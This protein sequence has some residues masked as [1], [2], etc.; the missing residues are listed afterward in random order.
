MLVRGKK[1]T[2]LFS[3]ILESAH[4]CEEDLM[5]QINDYFCVLRALSI[6]R[7]CIFTCM[8]LGYNHVFGI[9]VKQCRNRK[10]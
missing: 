4:V 5:I 2:H 6:E 8:S 10:S 3:Y 7:V 9:V 1:N